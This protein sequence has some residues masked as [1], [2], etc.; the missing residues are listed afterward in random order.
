MHE[1]LALAMD[2]L[3]FESFLETHENEEDIRSITNNKNNW[4]NMNGHK[5]LKNC[6]LLMKCMISQ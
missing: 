2:K 3:H 5:K 6:W 4:M 1:I